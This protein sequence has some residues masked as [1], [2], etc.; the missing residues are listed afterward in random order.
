MKL[1]VRAIVVCL[2]CFTNVSAEEFFEE[3]RKILLRG[4]MD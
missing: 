1:W 2:N 4:V 3:S